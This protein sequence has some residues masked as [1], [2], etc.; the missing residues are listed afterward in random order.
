[1]QLKVQR[2]VDFDF[3]RLLWSEDH[4]ESS[5]QTKLKGLVDSLPGFIGQLAA[6]CIWSSY[7]HLAEGT[8]AVATSIRSNSHWWGSCLYSKVGMGHSCHMLSL[9]VWRV[10]TLQKTFKILVKYVV[11]SQTSI[12][13]CSPLFT[14]N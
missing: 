14:I 7:I 10:H 11:C 1:M 4:D 9:C 12:Y 2:F 8:A 3:C 5:P 6:H 13:Y